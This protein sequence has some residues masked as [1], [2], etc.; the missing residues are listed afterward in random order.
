MG[1]EVEAVF[2][3][4]SYPKNCWVSTSRKILLNQSVRLITMK[5]CQHRPKDRPH[6]QYVKIWRHCN[7]KKLVPYH[8]SL[9]FFAKKL[10]KKVL[11][12]WR[13]KS[14]SWCCF[15]CQPMMKQIIS[16]TLWT[17][18]VVKAALFYLLNVH[19]QVR[20]KSVILW[21]PSL[22]KDYSP[23]TQ[24]QGKLSSLPLDSLP[25]THTWMFK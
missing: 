18:D 3:E 12:P 25:P 8:V 5:I 20:P 9:I 11:V 6:T 16:S 23:G 15:I 4:F 1:L 13:R 14:F 2:C 19:Q 17:G 24:C 22:R 7:Y 21:H 10:A